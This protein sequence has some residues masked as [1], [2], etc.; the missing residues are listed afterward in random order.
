MVEPRISSTFRRAPFHFLIWALLGILDF[1]PATPTTFAQ[2]CG[3]VPYSFQTALAGAQR[4]DAEYMAVLSEHYYCGIGVGQN[5]SEAFRWALA[6]ANKNATTAMAFVGYF[7]E[8]GKGVARNDQTAGSWYL[9]AAQ[10]GSAQ[11]Y[12]GL[13]RL[14]KAGRYHPQSKNEADYLALYVKAQ[15][16]FAAKQYSV[17][18]PTLKRAAELG[19][20]WAAHDVGIQYEFGDGVPASSQTAL[21]WYESCAK[22]GNQA[23]SQSFKSL[24]QRIA[25]AAP[26]KPC[27]YWDRNQF[28]TPACK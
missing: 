27:S 4:G 25:A 1:F 14:Y 8:T 9:R 12:N 19:W 2:T 24:S 10:A 7:Y 23:C 16:A 26:K 28:G 11:G 3:N 17:S 21:Q 15:Q 20:S 13:L 18:L 5:P 22:T 6:A